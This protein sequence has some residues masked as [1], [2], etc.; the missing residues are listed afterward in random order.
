MRA[1]PSGLTIENSA[2]KAMRKLLIVPLK[3]HIPDRN[4]YD[5]AGLYK[6]SS[7]LRRHP[8]LLLLEGQPPGIAALD[9]NEADLSSMLLCR[10]LS[11]HAQMRPRHHME[12]GE[13]GP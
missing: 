6:R 8:A 11:R 3:T 4:R 2:G 1:M 7:G 5:F 13:P 9:G 12:F 10:I